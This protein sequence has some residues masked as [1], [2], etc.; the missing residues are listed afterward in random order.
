MCIRDSYNKQ[1][2]EDKNRISENTIAFLNDRIASV[3]SE[4][5]GEE[6]SVERFKNKN[7]LTDLSSDAQQYLESSQQVDAQKAQAETKLNIIRTLEKNL[8]VAQD[9]PQVVPSTLGL[10]DPTLE[11]LI[12]KHNE[13]ALQKAKLKE[14]VGA[15]HPMMIDL[16]NQ[17]C[18]L[19]TSDAA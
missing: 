15:N 17:I 13:L 8:Q 5:Q 6:S 3:R 4:M 10:E 2:L 9:N 12:E 7:K 16:D 14:K 11:K 18:L 19:Y 1:G